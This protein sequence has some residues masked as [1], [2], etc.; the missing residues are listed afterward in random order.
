MIFKE[1]THRHKWSSRL[2][3]AL[4]A[5][6][7]LLL[8]Q[9]PSTVEADEAMPLWFAQNVGQRSPDVAFHT[10]GAGDEISF[11]PTG[12]SIG[13]LALRFD[14]AATP[15]P[16]GSDAIAKTA[17]FNFADDP[18]APLTDV[19][20]FTALRY[21][22]LYAGIDLSYSGEIGTLSRRFEVA[23]G[24]DPSQIRMRYGS[25]LSPV[26]TPGGSLELRE[27]ATAIA[28]DAAP[29]AY[30][31]A[32]V[33]KIAVP[34]DFAIAPDGAVLLSLGGHDPAKALF[35]ELHLDLETIIDMAVETA[36]RQ[37][38]DGAGGSSAAVI[39]TQPSDV[40]DFEA[41]V[42]AARESVA[43]G[44]GQAARPAGIDALIPNGD[45]GGADI[46]P[47][48]GDTLSGSYTNVGTFH[49]QAGVTVG[50]VGAVP[51]FV[52][53][54]EII[55]EG[56]LDGMGGGALG[57]VTTALN[58][59]VTGGGPGG[60]S[61]GLIGPSIH[62]PG[63][64][65]AGYGGV[66]GGGGR[67]LSTPAE[68][69]GGPTYGMANP[70]GIEPGSGGGSAASHT[71]G[72]PPAI[73]GPGGAGGAGITLMATQRI[74]V[75]GG[76]ILADGADGGDGLPGQFGAGIGISGGGAGSG[77]GI[78][79]D[80]CLDLNNATFS[81]DG[82]AGGDAVGT[83][84]FRVGG[85]GG[86][87]GRIKLSGTQSPGSTYAT[88]V[89]GGPAGS[90]AGYAANLDPSPG[91]DGSVVDETT[92]EACAAGPGPGPGAV[93][94]SGIGEVELVAQ[95]RTVDAGSGAARELLLAL[96]LALAIAGA[97]ALG[98]RRRVA[99]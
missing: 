94:G 19:P 48:D 24:G 77:G 83:G 3:T 10:V 43:D 71:G 30:Q 91:A 2:G 37:S 56:V 53:A 39:F 81:A 23:P 42:D 26:V 98:W 73:G 80:G 5:L 17:E 21:E 34:V 60:G 84:G 79:L 6:G 41:F 74:A 12:A 45:Q 1:A 38:L 82:G 76:S 14:G 8:A 52:A 75:D 70:P 44:Q 49:V 97:A 58:P 78:W 93:G 85:G 99:R 96:A 20:I 33:S 67:T 54:E 64:G 95:A 90:N 55:I 7:L 35:L 51:L 40:L 28:T 63:G 86:G 87:G 22:D 89:G 72:A 31:L 68:A 46:V 47:A 18:G 32:G 16:S 57:G 4:A 27:G 11:A 9:A 92:P 61:G 36:V 65:G 13:A 15:A 66:G 50:V 59:G 29:I 69:P 62:A 25:G 88:S